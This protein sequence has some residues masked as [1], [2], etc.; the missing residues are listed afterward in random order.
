M[1]FEEY[2]DAVCEKNFAF[3]DREQVNIKVTSIKALMQQAYERG[4]ESQ[5][6]DEDDLPFTNTAKPFSS[7]ANFNNLFDMF[8]MK[9]P[10]NNQK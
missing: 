6:D 7:D 8:G 2:W 5:Y 9:R 4:V 10:N 3:K 1:K